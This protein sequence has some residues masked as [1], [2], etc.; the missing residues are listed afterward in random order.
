VGAASWPLRLPRHGSTRFQGLFTPLAGVLFT[1]P[2]RY[3]T[4]SVAACSLPWTVVS[5][6]S[7]QV[8][9]AR[10]YSG[11]Q[12]GSVGAAYGT[13]TRS[14]AVFQTASASPGG[15]TEVHQHLGLHPT[16]PIRQRLVPWHRTGLGVDP[17]RSPLLR[18][19]FSLPPATEMF[20][21]AGYPPSMTVSPRR[22]WVAPFGNLWITACLRLPKA[23]RSG[24]PSFIGT[25]R[26]GIHR[27]L[28]LSSLPTR[29]GRG[30]G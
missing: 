30:Q 15:P 13:L 1:I 27:V 4:L 11:V 25:Q 14:G 7:A 17:V 8:L 19:W 9:R 6:A 24:A 28:I 22:G 3:C 21:L 18:V 26:Q 2:S 5:P 16:T 20:Q 10:T 23:Y 12:R 29:A